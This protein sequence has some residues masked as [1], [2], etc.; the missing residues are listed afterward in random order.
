MFSE[1]FKAL[2]VMLLIFFLGERGRRRKK[3]EKA[4]IF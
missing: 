2:K 3:E 4:P 1:R